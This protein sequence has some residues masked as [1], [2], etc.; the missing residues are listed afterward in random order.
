DTIT[1]G[2]DAA[3]Q[4]LA[5]MAIQGIDLQKIERQLQADAIKDIRQ[6]YQNLEN[7][8]IRRRDELADTY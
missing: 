3:E 2:R 7:N 6:S 5:E 1:A 8:V 4:T